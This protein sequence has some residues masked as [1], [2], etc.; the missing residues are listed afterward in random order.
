M[1][2]PG[3]TVTIE[4]ERE[5][6]V[7]AI[8]VT[9][10]TDV[11]KDRFGQTF[12]RGLLGV[13]PVVIVFEPVPPLKLVPAATSYVVQMTRTML[14]TADRSAYI[15]RRAKGRVLPYFCPWPNR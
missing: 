4:L 1:L 8:R 12:R 2:R 14:N 7:R 5:Q 9:L 15:V 13:S 3:E 11:E 6:V 10:G